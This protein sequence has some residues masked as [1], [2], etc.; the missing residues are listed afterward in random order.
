[1]FIR[2]KKEN[3]ERQWCST[4]FYIHR[5][6]LGIVKPKI[7]YLT[8][9]FEEIFS[10][11]IFQSTKLFFSQQFQIILHS[12]QNPRGML[13]RELQELSSFVRNQREYPNSLFKSC[14]SP[15]ILN[16][17]SNWWIDRV[18]SEWPIYG[19]CLPSSGIRLPSPRPT[20]LTLSE[21]GY[22]FTMYGNLLKDFHTTSH[23]YYWDSLI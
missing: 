7:R 11:L 12:L 18:V 16:C 10:H 19:E 22:P 2:N 17:S 23:G 3:T 20:E 15:V 1:M 21:L 4:I 8:W 9:V 5:Q 6:Y 14:C 13:Q